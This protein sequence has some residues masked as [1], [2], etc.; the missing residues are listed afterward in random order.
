MRA[1]AH[2]RQTLYILQTLI[3]LEDSLISWLPQDSMGVQ[4]SPL[5]SEDQLA[6]VI[7][8]AEEIAPCE[9]E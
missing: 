2:S 5:S 8:D 3:G 1:V 6:G 4:P 7:K 9:A